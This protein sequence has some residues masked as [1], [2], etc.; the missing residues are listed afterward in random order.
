[1]RI[2]WNQAELEMRRADYVAC[3]TTHFPRSVA[4]TQND[5]MFN[6]VDG[7]TDY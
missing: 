1:M 4:K 6:A 7:S 3:D 5:M 2:R